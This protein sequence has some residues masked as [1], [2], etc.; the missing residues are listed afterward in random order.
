MQGKPKRNKRP[1][2]RTAIIRISYSILLLV[3]VVASATTVF[4]LKTKEFAYDTAIQESSVVVEVAVVPKIAFPIGVN[5][6]SKLISENPLVDTYFETHI[7]KTGRSEDKISWWAKH[8]TA[9]LAMFSWYQNL[10]S[11]LSRILVVDS[12]ERKE[13]VGDN[14]AAI[15]RW[16]ADEELKFTSMV[17]GSS[18]K[19]SDGK[20]FPGH[21]VVSTEATPEEVAQILI[22]QF[23]A[24]VASRYTSEIE[25]VVPLED[26]LIIA[27]LL[28]R[29]AYDFEDMR[30]IAGV[31]WN[32]LFIGMNLQ[33]DASLQ[34]AKAN[35]TNVAWWPV[36]K[37]EDKY[38]ESPFNTYENKGLPPSPIANPSTEAILAAINPKQTDCIFYFHDRDGGFHCTATYKEHVTLLKEYYGRGR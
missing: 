14:F 11:P 28:E 16:T 7:S 13:E 26:T 31:I 4:L 1:L 29:E 18:P 37:P 10:A 32:R 15:L 8:V 17:A 38:V 27:S 23:D 34:Y 35:E 2:G 12:G 36:V 19:I 9:K 25:A 20:F 33:I 21:Y 3:C 5:P 6:L 22:D 30:Y 24:N